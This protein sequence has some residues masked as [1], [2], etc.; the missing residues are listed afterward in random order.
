MDRCPSED[1]CALLQQ[2][3]ERLAAQLGATEAALHEAERALRTAKLRIA[4]LE[5]RLEYQ[6]QPERSPGPCPRCA[7]VAHALERMQERQRER[8]AYVVQ[9][10]REGVQKDAGIVRLEKRV[11]ELETKVHR[12]A[13]PYRRRPEQRQK[14]PKPPGR[15]K[16]HAASYRPL[17]EEQIQETVTVPLEH[18][19]HCEGPVKERHPVA[20]VIVDL[21]RVQPIVWRLITFTGECPR[22]GK[23]RS[24]HPDQVST[25]T[26]AAGFQLGRQALGVA[27]TLRHG[28]GLPLRRVSAILKDLFH[29]SV[30]HAGIYEALARMAH[31]LVPEYEGLKE[32]LRQSGSVHADETGWWLVYRGGW[33]WVFATGETTAYLITRKRS[34]AAI[35]EVLGPRF[36]GVLVSDCLRVYDRYEAKAKSKCV[37]HHLRKIDEAQKKRPESAFLAAMKRLLQA[38]LKLQR[39]HT[40]LPDPVY[41][42]GVASMERR[43]TQLLEPTYP[44]EEEEKVAQRFRNQRAHLF[45]FLRHPEVAATNNLAERQL[46]PAVITRKLSY[47]NATEGGARTL[48]VLTSL[49]ATCRQRGASFIAFIANRAKLGS[50]PTGLSPPSP[51]LT[52]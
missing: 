6:R 50:V 35:Q 40:W 4:T 29:L 19:P 23:V 7:Q 39:A 9:L 31:K 12:S 32:A 20:Q 41:Q 26:G 24:T 51:S 17:P 15:E 10:E 28:H 25:A 44:H 42:R 21:P 37:S 22:C 38:S 45:T 3:N 47:G 18:C 36:E 30:S 52:G 5:Q 43:M 34:M 33:L 13:A 16:G 27:A 1:P 11:A 49:A 48:E 2:E 14:D 46:R 8:E